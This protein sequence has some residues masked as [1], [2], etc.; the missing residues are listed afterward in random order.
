MNCPRLRQSCVELV[1]G[2]LIGRC[3]FWRR[4]LIDKQCFS[5]LKRHRHLLLP[6][7]CKD[8]FS[9]SQCFHMVA[10]FCYLLQM[11]RRM[12]KMVN[13]AH[14]EHLHL[15]PLLVHVTHR[16]RYSP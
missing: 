5:L 3:F 9:A 15:V 12:K 1:V 13:C 8:G 2:L 16:R 11:K 10:I 14:W 4:V 7:R 6:Q